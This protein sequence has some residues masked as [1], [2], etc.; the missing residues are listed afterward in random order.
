MAYKGRLGAKDAEPTTN[1][2]STQACAKEGLGHVVDSQLIL[3]YSSRQKR[4]LSTG[5]LSLHH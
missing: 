1:M 5:A 2:A 4:P 3:I